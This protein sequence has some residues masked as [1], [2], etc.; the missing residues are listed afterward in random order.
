M[1]INHRHYYELTQ[2]DTRCDMWCL[3]VLPIV[4]LPD[5]SVVVFV[6]VQLL[7]LVDIIATNAVAETIERHLVASNT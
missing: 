2:I 1:F 4:P 7:V 5:L 3:L 6:A